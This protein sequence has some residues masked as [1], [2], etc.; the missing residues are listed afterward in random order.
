MPGRVF[1]AADRFLNLR[2]HLIVIDVRP[3][4]RHQFEIRRESLRLAR[5]VDH[6]VPEIP[7][8]A[9]AAA[10]N[11]HGDEPRV[12]EPKVKDPDALL[13]FFRDERPANFPLIETAGRLGKCQ[14][15]RR[16]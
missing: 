15:Q 8:D 13:G 14:R 4:V 10:G 16:H 11:V 3:V 6:L 2:Q 7:N 5:A 1:N 9:L 12:L